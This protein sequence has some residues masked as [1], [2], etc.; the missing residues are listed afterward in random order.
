MILNKAAFGT[1]HIQSLRN[2]G[3]QPYNTW[4]AGLQFIMAPY[5]ADPWLVA[6]ADTAAASGKLAAIFSPDGD[7]LAYVGALNSLVS[8]IPL[9]GSLLVL[10][11]SIADTED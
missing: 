2:K 8:E 6:L 10:T 5:E 4:T 7:T 3:V 9:F 11:I 1:V